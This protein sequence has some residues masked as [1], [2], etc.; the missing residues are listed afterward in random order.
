MFWFRKRSGDDVAWYRH[1]NYKGDLNEDEKM[2]LDSIRWQAKS[3]RHPSAKIEDLPNEVVDYISDLEFE[4]MRSRKSPHE[5]TVLIAFS[6]FVYCILSGFE[7]IEAI[8]YSEKVWIL[9]PISII[10][11]CNGFYNIN[12]LDNFD[13]QSD[14]KLM[15]KWELDY[16]IFKRRSN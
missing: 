11:F 6:L 5:W 16:I 4:C 7:I 15:E 9:L 1:R 3:Q 12:K 10:F 8:E 2:E 13:F 14:Q